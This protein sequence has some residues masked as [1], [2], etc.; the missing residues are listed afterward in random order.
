MSSCIK[1]QGDPHN[2]H[3]G[4][5]EEQRGGQAAGGALVTCPRMA[6]PVGRDLEIV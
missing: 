4:L 6:V 3:C 5:G 1:H 2:V